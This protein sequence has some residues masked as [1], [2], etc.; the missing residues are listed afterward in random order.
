MM[1]IAGPGEVHLE[2][3]P[4]ALGQEL[5]GRALPLVLRRFAGH[6]HVAAERDGA[7]AVLRAAAR[8]LQDLGAESERKRQHPDAVPARHQEMAQLVHEDEDAEDE[9]K[10]RGSCHAPR[11]MVADGWFRAKK[12]APTRRSRER[13]ESVDG[14][15]LSRSLA[16]SAASI[17]VG[18]AGKRKPAGQELLHR[19]FVR[20]VEHDRPRAALL[21][22]V[23][24]QPQARKPLKIR[25]QRTRACRA[26][27]TSSGGS[28]PSQRSGYA[29]AY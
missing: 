23:V 25:R 18:I 24:G 6:L 26:G 16:F 7:D 8:E 21:Q 14:A 9:Q 1:F 19:D 11:K 28:A 17:T 13:R 2:P 4:L 15:R 20:G 3:D 22:R 5:V 29:N 27:S 12:P 10:R